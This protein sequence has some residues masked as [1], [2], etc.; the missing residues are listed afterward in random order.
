MQPL[1]ARVHHSQRRLRPELGLLAA[2]GLLASCAG[3]RPDTTAEATVAVVPPVASPDRSGKITVGELDQLTY[4]F[5]DRYFMTISSAVDRLKRENSD[6]EQRRTAHRLKVIGVLAMNDIASSQDPSSQVLNLLVAVTLQTRVWIDEGRAFAVFGDRAPILVQALIEIRRDV[7]NLAE[8]VMTPDQMERLELMIT[9]WRRQHP[10]QDQV[11]FVKFDEF[12][13]SKASN[14]AKEMSSSGGLLAPLDD[15]N[16]ELV[17]YRRL[18]E[19]AFWYTKRAPSIAGIQAEGATNEIMASPEIANLFANVDRVTA[20]AER[21]DQRI[22]DTVATI[23]E[24]GPTIASATKELLGSTA[25]VLQETRLT[26]AQVESGLKTLHE[27][28][29][30]LLDPPATPG[31]PFNIVEYTEALRASADVL[32]EANTLA[33]QSPTASALVTEQL[34]NVAT[35]TDQRL[36]RVFTLIWI[37]IGLLF[38]CG[39]AWIALFRFSARKQS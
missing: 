10:Q 37:T 1:P 26:I 29:P 7:W 15:A 11:A 25:G 16:R 20:T 35:F 21:L 13:A 27:L 34:R 39:A 5:A 24:H 8:R 14:L 33:G 19:R 17:E 12:A 36:Q 31:R 3:S 18:A 30:H 38:V 2:A 23:T 6:P 32:R 28:Y 22:G 9:G 4:A